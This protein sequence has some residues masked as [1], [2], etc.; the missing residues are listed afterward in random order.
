MVNLTET[1]SEE[2][3]VQFI[4]DYTLEKN[5]KSDVEMLINRLPVIREK[6]D[7]SELYTD[8]GYYSN[9]I[10][11]I[12]KDNEVKVNFTD[13][14][15]RKANP[16]KLPLSDFTIEDQKKI[17]ACPQGQVPVQSY[18]NYYNEVKKGLTAYF[19]PDVC[20]QCPHKDNCPVKIQKKKAVLKVSQKAVLAAETRKEIN[21]EEQRQANISKRAAI[22]GTN[23][24]LKRS[25]GTDK[26]DVR[27]QVKCCL[28]VGMKIIG[29][30]FQQ[31]KKFFKDSAKL[32]LPTTKGVT[33]PV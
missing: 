29:H 28:A 3:P 15:G 18:Y 31:L 10:Q 27:G 25:Q 8:G 33:V 16:E 13:M 11:Q 20:N 19:E 12:S 9:E 5:T 24:A 22:E 30:N 32:N 6:T 7:I 14:T 17:T 21:D 23:S 26:L 2:N 1:C 4:T